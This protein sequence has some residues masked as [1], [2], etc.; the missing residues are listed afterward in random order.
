MVDARRERPSRRGQAERAHV[1]FT[2]WNFQG[3]WVGTFPSFSKVRQH[4][5]VQGVPGGAV[6]E[7][8]GRQ[9]GR[10]HGLAQ[11]P[12]LR[13]EQGGHAVAGHPVYL[14]QEL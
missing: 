10:L 6:R 7:E 5:E 8:L 9:A 14:Q 1:G 11:L 4:S 2:R 12:C 3:K 13:R